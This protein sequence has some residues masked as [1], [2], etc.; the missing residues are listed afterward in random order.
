MTDPGD[1]T[2]LF[3]SESVGE[4]HPDKMCDQISDAILDECLRNDPL[5]KVACETATKTGMIMVL[6]EITTKSRLDYQK[7][8]RE[9]V[10]EIGFDDSSKGFDYKTCNVLVAIEQQ[11]PDI[12]QGV[13]QGRIAEDVGAGDQGL[14][15]GYATDET[16]DY[17]PLTIILAHKMNRRMSEL[18]RNGKLSWIRPDSK[19]QVTIEYKADGGAV[20]PL[21][22]HTV[23][24]SVQHSP[25]V[26]MEQMKK[27]LKEHVIQHVVPSKYLDDRTIYHLQPSGKFVIGG[28]QGDA[29]VTGRKIIVDTYGGWGAHGGGAFSGKDPTKVDRSG[30]YAAR[31]VA[32]SLVAAKLCRRVLLQI[33]YAIGIAEPLAIHVDSYGT[34]DD[35]TLL[36]I[37]KKNFDLRPGVIIKSLDLT[38]PVYKE[39]AK[40][41]HFGRNQFTWE[42]PK[43]LDLDTSVISTDI[44]VFQRMQCFAMKLYLGRNSASLKCLIVAKATESSVDVTFSR[45]ARFHNPLQGDVELPVLEEKP[46]SFA[47]GAKSACAVLWRTSGRETGKTDESW[48]EATEKILE[49]DDDSKDFL[50]K[51]NESLKNRS[52]EETFSLD[53]LIVLGFVYDIVRNKTDEFSKFPHFNAW[54]KKLTGIPQIR[55][56]ISQWESTT[57]AHEHW[58]KGASILPK[59]KARKHPV[60]PSPGERNVLITSALPYVNNIP[61]L[62]NIIGC[63]LSAD[64]FSRYSRLRGYNVVYICGSDEYGT[65][66]ETK[67][68]EEGMTPREICDKYNVLHKEIYEWFNIDF[69]IFGR[70]TTSQQT[71]IAQ[72]IFW[73]L[74]RRGYLSKDKVEQLLCEK[75]NRFLADRFVEGTCP[76]C[77]YPDARGDQCDKCGKLIN[78]VELKEPRC[79]VCSSCPVLKTSDHLFL[80]LGK[81]DPELRQ[82]S[83]KSMNEGH[84]SSSA[85]VITNTWIRDGVKSRCIT[86]D[87]KWGTP[88]PLEGYTDKVFYVWFDAPI[89]YLSITANYTP[90]WDKWWKNP[91]QVELFQFMAKDNVPFHS[92]VFPCSLLGTG[93]NY[94][95]VNHLSATDYLNY[96]GGKFSKSRGVGVFGNDAMEADI[97]A[98]VWRFYLLY[99]RPE[100]QDSQFSW[101]DFALKNNTELLN[102]LGNF[103]NRALTFA[104][105]FFDGR[106]PEMD[107]LESDYEL[108]GQINEEIDAYVKHLEELRIRDGLKSILAI[109]RLG[110]GFI[111]ATKPWELVKKS[112][113]ERSRAGTVIG[114]AVNVTWLLAVLLH[115]YMPN[116]SQIVM[117]QIQAP[118]HLLVIPAHLTE[119]LSQGHKLGETFP[120][121]QKIDDDKAASLKAKYGGKQQVKP[122]SKKPG[123]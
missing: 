4:G 85:Q 3:T 55:A 94:T 123:K 40:Y 43:K 9:T 118:E 24:I 101:N 80:D 116:I 105:K 62:G 2:F 84:W 34:G 88:V 99:V 74:Y 10:K 100:N 113:T 31:W 45:S 68:L 49:H 21:R 69:D 53:D 96:E 32:K 104:E 111:Q 81:L 95:L 33:S 1:G 52:Q 97:P 38:K 25:D 11:S 13:H 121:F 51:F 76:L 67:A 71:E 92:V 70:T 14:M 122:S 29:G 112:S 8:V 17:M 115:P 120:L 50:G 16:E 46:G 77:N 75:C 30:A 54:W 59:P 12:A 91:K 22:V 89:G 106:V 103:I 72:D 58:T 18:R 61:H 20:V 6:G 39:A 23:V 41:G 36:K 107:L 78:A 57:S 48:I 42:K 108:V 26:L 86:R 28:P 27:D 47:I 117:K 109:S 15:F 63:V 65:A 35:K 44:S 19:T 110:N 93:D 87:L 98:D 90:E 82:W 119:V 79:K 7:I 37:I 66:T 102:N 114:V 83:Q 5:S 60:L 73:K 56:A 64:V